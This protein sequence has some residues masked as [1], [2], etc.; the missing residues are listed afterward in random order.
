M[1]HDAQKKKKQVFVL[2]S[3]L[4]QFHV[5]SWHRENHLGSR[6]EFLQSREKI[7]IF[8]FLVRILKFLFTIQCEAAYNIFTP[9]NQLAHGKTSGTESHSL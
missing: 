5:E 3:S 6:R 9:E 4:K 2:S 7:S 8:F 1:K